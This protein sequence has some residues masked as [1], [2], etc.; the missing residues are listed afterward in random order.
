MII[1]GDSLLK[2]VMLLKLL[3]NEKVSVKSFSGA[4]AKEMS[5]YIKPT[6]EEK[7]DDTILHIGENDLRWGDESNK[8]A[9]DILNLA[10][11]CKQTGCEV[12][13]SALQ[14]RR[15]KFMVKFVKEVND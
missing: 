11:E 7:H 5:T 9:N 8:I 13:I 2:I 14:P 10:T 12:T 15:D 4:T 1:L 6:I 3:T